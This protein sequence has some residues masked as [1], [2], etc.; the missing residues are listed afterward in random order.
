MKNFD[1]NF[2]LFMWLIG[3][4][5][6]IAILSGVY[7]SIQYQKVNDIYSCKRLCTNPLFHQDAFQQNMCYQNCNERF[8]Q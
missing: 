2:N 1:R 4:V 8:K 7:Y 5:F 3:S 6:A